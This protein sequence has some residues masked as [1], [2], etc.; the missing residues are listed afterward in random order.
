[1]HHSAASDC[2]VVAGAESLVAAEKDAVLQTVGEENVAVL[3]QI[4]VA[5]GVPDSL[6]VGE[7]RFALVALVVSVLYQTAES[8]FCFLH[9]SGQIEIGHMCDTFIGRGDGET[10]EGGADAADRSVGCG[11]AGMVDIVHDLMD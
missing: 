3:V 4:G 5:L 2:A 11:F 9:D 6:D 10:A 1:M 8:Q 7:R